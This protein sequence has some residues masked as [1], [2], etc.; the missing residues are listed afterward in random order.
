MVCNVREFFILSVCQIK[1]KRYF[2]LS[3]SGMSK[4][5]L[6]ELKN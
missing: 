2:I 4:K 1:Y 3:F 6:K 5:V